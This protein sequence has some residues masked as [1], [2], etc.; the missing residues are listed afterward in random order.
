MDRVSLPQKSQC[1]RVLEL[2]LVERVVNTPPIQELLVCSILTDLTMVEDK[3]PITILNRL[4]TMGN[5]H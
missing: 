3:H 4:E 5:H 2:Q 1:S